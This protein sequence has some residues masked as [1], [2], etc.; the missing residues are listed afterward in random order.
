MHGE[1]MARVEDGVVGD[2]HFG[3]LVSRPVR[4][5]YR[6][7]QRVRSGRLASRLQRFMC[8]VTRT[9][10]ARPAIACLLNIHIPADLISSSHAHTTASPRGAADRSDASASLRLSGHGKDASQTS[11]RLPEGMR[12]TCER[13]GRCGANGCSSASPTQ[14]WA[15]FFAK[16]TWTPIF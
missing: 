2:G 1:R 12:A 9:G 3:F 11:S 16:N 14:P 7:I 10:G 6:W 8:R 13:G 5:C 15:V 4:L